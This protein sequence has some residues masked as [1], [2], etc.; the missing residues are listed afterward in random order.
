MPYPPMDYGICPCCGVEYGLDDAF[1]SHLKLRNQWLKRG[2]PWF[3]QHH[4]YDPPANWNA[5]EQ[6]DLAGY[7]YDVVPPES[8][9]KTDVHFERLYS[10]V[11][12][13]D[14]VMGVAA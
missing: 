13:S 12:C 7:Q 5:W 1:D 11:M 8:S 14:C 6:L 2:A 9:I 4:P 3:S 10:S